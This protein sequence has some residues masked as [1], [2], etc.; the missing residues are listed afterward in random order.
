MSMHLRQIMRQFV[1]H[2]FEMDRR[3][4]GRL[5]WRQAINCRTNCRKFCRKSLARTPNDFYNDCERL[6]EEWGYTW[7]GGMPW[8]M[9][10]EEFSAGEL[11]KVGISFSQT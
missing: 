3:G 9:D 8:A 6:K 11:R 1:R 2:F 5:G 10:E 7:R 4:P